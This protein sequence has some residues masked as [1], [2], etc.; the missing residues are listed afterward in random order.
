MTK[1]LIVSGGL[2]RKLVIVLIMM[3]TLSVFA[4][5]I[6][7]VK[8]SKS[9]IIVDIY[10]GEY[11]YHSDEK[12]TYLDLTG[13]THRIDP[14]FPDL[15]F[16]VLN[17]AVPPG[18]DLDLKILNS[19]SEELRLT[20]PISPIPSI[21]SGSSTYDHIFQINEDSYLQ[22]PAT[23]VEKQKFTRFR[24]FTFYPIKL[25][26]F[27][28][29]YSK[30]ELKVTTHLRLEINIVGDI[31]YKK[32]ISDELKMI[33]KNFIFNYD[34]A[35]EWRSL[36]DK[37]F[38]K[39]PFSES[40]FW[41][42]LEVGQVGQYK[43]ESEQLLKLPNFC[44]PKTIRIFTMYKTSNINR[45]KVFQ[46]EE[47]PLQIVNKDEIGLSERD[48]IYF[49]HT[50]KIQENSKM[51]NEHVYWLTFGGTFSGSPKRIEEFEQIRS[52]Q[53]V[54]NFTR[55]LEY[56]NNSRNDLEMIIIYPSENVFKM[57]SEE[58]ALFHS[59]LVCE[60]KSQEEIF[61]EYSAG[62]VDQLAIKNYLEDTYLDNPN[63]Q[64]VLLVGSGSIQWDNTNEKN[65]I[66]CFQGTYG[67]VSD[68]YFVDFND[69][70]YP[71]LM[72]GRLPAQ[73]D[74]DLNFIVDRIQN[75]RL[76]PT[77]GFWRNK[78]LII[79]DDE[80]K[81]GG[82]EGMGASGM[83]H[84]RLA[85]ETDD[86]I[87][88]NIFVDKVFAFNYEL[89]EYE[90]KPEA[91]MDMVDTV[92]DGVLSWY[93]IGHGNEDVLGDEDY[94][95]GT[96]HL[97]L[98]N[99]TDYPNL[100]VAASCSVGKYHDVSFD[101]L[102][103]KLLFLENGGSIASIAATQACSPIPNTDLM[104]AFYQRVLN[105]GDNI[106]KALLYAKL[107][108][109]AS[110][111]NSNYYNILG[112]PA[113][114]IVPP[115]DTGVITGIQDSLQS[116]QLVDINGDFATRNALNGQGDIRVYEAEYE[117]TYVNLDYVN[118]T[119]D[120][121]F[122]YFT[123]NYT[124]NGNKFYFSDLNV[125]NNVYSSQY[126]VPDDINPGDSG[127]ILSY[128][129]DELTQKDYVNS[130]DSIHLSN[131]QLEVESLSPPEVKLYL[132]SET[133][134]AGDFV[135]TNPQLIAEIEDENGINILGD[136]GHRILLTIDEW[137]LPVDV[138][139]G[140]VYN[141]GSSTSGILT[142]QIN[143]LS[144]GTHSLQ[145]IVFDNFNDPTVAET[146]FVTKKEGN[147]VISNMLPYPNPMK[148]GGYFTFNITEDSKITISIYTLT[149]RKIRSINN[150]FLTAGFHKVYW[151]GKD[152]VGDEI[153]NNTYFYKIKAQNK[154]RSAEK[155]GKIIILK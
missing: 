143:G 15:P 13:W 74:N 12:F 131:V 40:D 39:M 26:P 58:L 20:K 103:E 135:S 149:G 11:E 30:N 107:N 100:F 120:T 136:A 91:R 99:N 96:L 45:D 68:D 151:N 114:K 86:L 144:E 66:I 84:S 9:Q 69:N 95:R 35:K 112:D 49:E 14:G 22:P 125:E 81:D 36:P 108:S 21:K 98:L 25:S 3:I 119:N 8:Q 83:N 89:D 146:S 16:K 87:D 10:V 44:D 141:N 57:Q 73:N 33:N 2:M 63:L 105:E 70:N 118:V 121:I 34:S 76:D 19:Q 92:N 104:K 153:A 52:A 72:I 126:F 64:Y 123:V 37:N 48:L 7:I 113:L 4:N 115:K 5:Q 29:D 101:C 28:Y 60:L 1:M 137:E 38:N 106:G 128:F 152:D 134:N 79:A 53:G 18:G 75:Y 138:T 55:K 133:F 42:R 94:F 148:D 23:R 117:R 47:I 139:P 154:G 71:E 130:L 27:L 54:I 116:R 97:N 82:Y 142:W 50:K 122:T 109:S 32:T 43:I 127:R 145:L 102:A 17:I 132:D 67:R 61:A 88:E 155:I 51:T 78:L 62:N 65:K 90:N 140:F 80:N 31:K 150:G 46:I 85:Q 59:E 93:Y 41:F 147:V 56:N 129:F 24:S 111:V 6:E 124:E 110:I 77:P